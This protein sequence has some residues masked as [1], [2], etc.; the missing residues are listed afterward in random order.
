MPYVIN[1]RP[2]DFYSQRNNKIKPLSACGPTSRVMFYLGNG[3]KFNN[4]SKMP[5]DDYFMNLLNS[6]RAHEYAKSKYPSLSK[7][8]PPNEI[9]G[10]YE[11]LDG[12]VCGK[13]VSKFNESGLTF[14]LA[15]DY[16]KAG[17]VIQVTGK[18]PDANINGHIQLL[19]GYNDKRLLIC[20]SFGDFRFNFNPLSQKKGRPHFGGY[21][22]PMT[23]EEFNTHLKWGDTKAYH[24]PLEV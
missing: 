8:Y 20:D 18:Y 4:N 3:I 15:M 22:V 9:H 1:I 10:M 12:A 17:K 14:D 16:V 13:I 7:E 5:H 21:G 2:K 6:E 24:E 19:S 11:W 23:R